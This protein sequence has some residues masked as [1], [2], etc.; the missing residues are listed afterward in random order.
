MDSNQQSTRLSG[1]HLRLFMAVLLQNDTVFQ[2]FYGKLTVEKFS[3][4][5]NQLLYRM[6]LDFWE[7]N[8]GSLPSEAEAYTEIENYFDQ[9]AD[10]ISDAGRDELEDILNYAY[11]PATFGADGPTSTKMTRFAFKAGK[12]FLQQAYLEQVTYELK[13]LPTLDSLTDF[14]SNAA[15]QSEWLAINEHSN[16][17]KLTLGVDG[18]WASKSPFLVQSTG[19]PFLDKYMSGGARKKEGYG[20]MAPYGTCKT[21]LAVMLWSLAAQ[22]CYEETLRDDWDGRKGLSFLVTYEAPLSPEI[23]HRVVMYSA[24]VH[25]NSL[26][27]MGIDG[28]KALQNDPENPLPYEKLKFKRQISDG[29][30]EPELSRV[31][32]VTPYINNHTVCL[33]LTGADEDWPHA[34]HGGITEIVQRIKLELRNRG[35]DHYVKNV[36][37][38]YLGLMV[39]QDGTLGTKKEDDHKLYQ[40]KVAELVRKVAVEM[41][42][43]LWVLHQLSG[44]ANSMLSPTKTLHHTDAKG[45]KSFAENLHF[46]FVVGNLNMDQLGQIACTKYRRARRQPPSIVR[47]EGEFNDV[48][49]PDN[50]HIDAKGQIVD[51]ETVAATGGATSFS[52]LAAHSNTNDYQTGGEPPMIVEEDDADDV[53]GENEE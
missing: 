49:A 40:K 26:E 45:S 31:K 5:S 33:D 42:C 38:D 43:H 28:L 6:L 17:P 19:I 12:R 23:Q 39:D 48:V 41:D 20:L 35:K 50:Y 51:K 18:E 30:F 47:V 34:G 22:Q 25:R 8:D 15:N 16:Q 44:S 2:Q 13:E 7:S 29:V 52:D 9:D 10:I 37:V 3:E 1:A 53:E 21:T 32:R 14:F 46:A 24:Q 11:D 36:I 4:E 27:S